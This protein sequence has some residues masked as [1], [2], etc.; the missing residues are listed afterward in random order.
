M[1]KDIQKAVGSHYAWKQAMVIENVNLPTCEYDI[2]A[3]TSAGQLHEVEVKISRSDFA[4]D[5]KKSKWRFYFPNPK[6]NYC[7][8]YFFYACPIGMIKPEEI[9]TWAGLMYF[10]NGKVWIEKKAKQLHKESVRPDI[11]N[12]MLRL[13]S[14]RH[15]L[16]GACMTVL[17]KRINERQ[18]LRE[19]WKSHWDEVCETCGLTGYAHEFPNHTCSQQPPIPNQ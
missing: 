10:E 18:L 2:A 19:E 8:N 5:K 9:P 6:P 1:T 11:S 15:F 4:A 14:Q 17:N 16:G 13:Y 3:I 7:P 12:K